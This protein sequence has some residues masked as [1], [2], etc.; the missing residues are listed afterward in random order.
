MLCSCVLVSPSNHT[1]L[2]LMAALSYDARAPSLAN[3]PFPSSARRKTA[4]F[5]P[6]MKAWRLGRLQRCAAERGHGEGGD[7][8]A[9]H[10]PCLSR[11][12]DGIVNFR[13][14]ALSVKFA[15]EDA[16]SMD[17]QGLATSK[18]TWAAL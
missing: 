17:D 6:C 18:P 4:L 5:R 15:S 3:R 9:P 8:P 12:H 2:V 11:R 1:L 10:L 16:C 13:S 7:R 14:R